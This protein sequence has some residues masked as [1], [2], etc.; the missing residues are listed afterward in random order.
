[1]NK[2]L[3][4]YVIRNSNL[5]EVDECAAIFVSGL[6]TMNKKLLTSNF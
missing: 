1:M 2:K 5:N 6:K 3:C 4:N